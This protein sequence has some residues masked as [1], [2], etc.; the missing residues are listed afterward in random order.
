MKND[1][2]ADGASTE[3]TNILDLLN[4]YRDVV[5]NIMCFMFDGTFLLGR[6]AD[7][8]GMPLESSYSGHVHKHIVSGAEVE[9]SR[10]AC[11]HVQDAGG[12]EGAG[13]YVT[14]ATTRSGET[15]CNNPYMQL[16]ITIH[17]LSGIYNENKIA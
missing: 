14:A 5:Y 17:H 10:S 13:C 11:G 3:I 7:G 12:K 15:K 8:E 2:A 9:P 16:T 6:T 4:F 1:S